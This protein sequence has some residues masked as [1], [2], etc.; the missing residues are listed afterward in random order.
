MSILKVNTVKSVN[1]TDRVR[2]PSG[3]QLDALAVGTINATGVSTFAGIGTFTTHLYSGGNISNTGNIT[4]TG[5]VTANAFAGNGS[6]LTGVSA[7]SAGGVNIGINT[8]IVY[9]LTTTTG[10]AVSYASGIATTKRMIVHSI[11]VT[12]ISGGDVELT[13]QIYTN[14]FYLAQEIPIPQKASME[15]LI[16]P[17]VLKAG[18][19]IQ[20][21]ASANNSLK[22]VITGEEITDAAG[23][24]FGKGLNIVNANTSYDLWDQNYNSMFTSC[25]L[26]N[27]NNDYDTR[28]TVTVQDAGSNDVGYYAYDIL[29]PANSSLELFESEKFLYSAYKIAVKSQIANSVDVVLTGKRVYT[30]N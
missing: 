6:A 10:V 8:S 13:S 15:L 20:M 2:F 4:A 11:Q 14:E 24:F 28:C 1:E 23:D 9:N 12:N 22:A 21:Q 17:K 27:K 29:V 3:I 19:G 5:T 18:D 7:Y 26:V 25:L 16:N 30:T